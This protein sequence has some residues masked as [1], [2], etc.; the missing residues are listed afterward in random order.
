MEIDTCK[1]TQ[2]TQ[3]N[4]HTNWTN[5]QKNKYDIKYTHVYKTHSQEK[6][7]IKM[8]WKNI[9][10]RYLQEFREIQETTLT[11]K[12]KRKF[13]LVTFRKLYKEDVG[14]AYV[15]EKNDIKGVLVMIIW[16]IFVYWIHI[17]FQRSSLFIRLT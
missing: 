4:R 2:Y 14:L 12:K 15:I 9:N 8:W 7:N 6:W 11:S 17:N 1:I 5:I 13:N 3:T 16:F 10:F